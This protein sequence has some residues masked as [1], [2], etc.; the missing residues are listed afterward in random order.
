MEKDQLNYPQTNVQTEQP[1]LNA[2]ELLWKY[3]QYGW[4]FVLIITLSMLIAWL[5][6]RYTQPIYSVS[7]TLLIRNDN[8]KRGG[9]NSSQDMFADIALFE[10]NTNKQ[11]EILILSSRTM[12]ERVVRSLE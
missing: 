12:M 3:I 11:N 9:G 2:K 1:T 10:S 6:L 8:A 7:S 4:L 5:Y